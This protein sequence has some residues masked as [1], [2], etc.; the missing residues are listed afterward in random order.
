MA[1]REEKNNPPPT[2]LK[3]CCQR[4]IENEPMSERTNMYQFL[5]FDQHERERERRKTQEEKQKKYWPK[6]RNNS[7]MRTS[8]LPK[9]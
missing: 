3:S 1:M 9:T 4:E 7:H 2:K 8:Q 5:I 6:E